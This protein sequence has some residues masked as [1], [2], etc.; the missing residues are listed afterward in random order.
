MWVSVLYHVQ[1]RELIKDVIRLFESLNKITFKGWYMQ[2]SARK[3]VEKE[4]RR[5]A[6]RYIRRYGLNI[7]DVDELSDKLM[8]LIYE[9]GT[10]G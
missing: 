5:F 10:K 2:Q 8:G 9:Y 6:R 1:K 3:D 7:K 4:V